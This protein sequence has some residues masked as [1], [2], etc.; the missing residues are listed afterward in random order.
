MEKLVGSLQEAD[1]NM[2][3]I[4]KQDET[5]KVLTVT[6]QRLRQGLERV[7]P[8]L[9][10]L[11]EAGT[12]VIGSTRQELLL[13]AGHVLQSMIKGRFVETL[14][15]EW[16]DLREKG[17]IE[18]NYSETPQQ[19]ACLQ[20]LLNFID[21]DLPDDVRFNTM[22]QVFLR[23]ATE[24]ESDRDSPLPQQFMIAC[25]ELSSGEILVLKAAYEIAEEGDWKSK[26]LQIDPNSTADIHIRRWSNAVASHSAMTH[27]ELVAKHAV[28]LQKQRLLSASNKTANADVFIATTEHFGLTSFGYAL[29]GFMTSDGPIAELGRT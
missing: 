25:R 23:A 22:K 11:S 1:G 12:G 26:Y 15:H 4:T 8:G 20:E 14:K 18:A 9:E 16:D 24:E 7:N 13:S 5:S 27:W 29:C 19:Q 6:L 17:R 2:E 28:S 3:E 10:S 21:I